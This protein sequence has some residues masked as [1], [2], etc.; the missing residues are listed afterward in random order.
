M[1]CDRGLTSQAQGT[2]NNLLDISPC[3]RIVRYTLQPEVRI[4]LIRHP[5]RIAQSL[6]LDRDDSSKLLAVSA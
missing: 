6:C 3:P 2:L 1:Y 4:A 5:I